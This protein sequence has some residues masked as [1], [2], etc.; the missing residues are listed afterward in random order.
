MTALTLLEILYLNN[1]TILPAQA[2]ELACNGNIIDVETVGRTITGA[3]HYIYT[4]V[5]GQI[6]HIF[7]KNFL[8]HGGMKE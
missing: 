1:A 5:T 7:T 3:M 2:E 4:L 6:V 8:I